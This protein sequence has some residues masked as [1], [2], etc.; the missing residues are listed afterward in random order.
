MT[1][2]YIIAL[3]KPGHMVPKNAD[4]AGFTVQAFILFCQGN[5]DGASFQ[6]V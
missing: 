4:F 2:R 3:A 1:P 6:T 5:V